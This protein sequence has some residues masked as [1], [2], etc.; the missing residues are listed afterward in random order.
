LKGQDVDGRMGSEWIKGDWPA[1]CRLDAVGSGQGPVAGCCEYGD[2]PPGSGTELA[3]YGDRIVVTCTVLGQC[4]G[5]SSS[6]EE[7]G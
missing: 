2:E 7:A 5:V 3:S 4:C 6:C 1:E